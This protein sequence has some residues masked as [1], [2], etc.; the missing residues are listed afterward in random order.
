MVY[1]NAYTVL[2]LPRPSYEFYVKY[3][4]VLESM[5]AEVSRKISS[6]D[7]AGFTGF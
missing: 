7:N 1:C 3:K 6:N 2:F 4:K 5:R